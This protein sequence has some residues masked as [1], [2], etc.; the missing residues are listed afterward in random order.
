MRAFLISVGQPIRDSHATTAGLKVFNQ[1]HG[2]VLKDYGLGIFSNVMEAASNP[3]DHIIDGLGRLTETVGDAIAT[4][5]STALGKDVS[6]H[7]LQDKDAVLKQ[8]VDPALGLGHTREEWQV[9]QGTN[10]EGY[11]YTTFRHKRFGILVELCHE[12]YGSFN[13]KLCEG[14]LVRR[15]TAITDFILENRDYLHHPDLAKELQDKSDTDQYALCRYPVVP[16]GNWEARS[17]HQGVQ[18]QHHSKMDK[19]NVTLVLIPDG[20]LF[21]SRGD[22]CNL[23]NYRTRE[24]LAVRAGAS[25]VHE[26]VISIGEAKSLLCKLLG[27]LRGFCCV[28][29]RTLSVCC[30]PW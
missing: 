22:T 7:G 2:G 16:A 23:S 19:N 24:A 29:P 25:G 6:E 14:M 18:I 26:A 15:C 20:F 11:E 8:S 27:P 30:R 12:S 1:E 5:A 28:S 4:K 10:A 3:M 13:Y 21:F 17:L 9:A